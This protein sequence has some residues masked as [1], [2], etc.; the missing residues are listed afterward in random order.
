MLDRN[1]PLVEYKIEPLKIFPGEIQSALTEYDS[2]K[3]KSIFHPISEGIIALK[4]F[5]EE[6]KDYEEE[7]SIEQL[8]KLVEIINAIN[9]NSVATSN[10]KKALVNLIEKLKPI[11]A[12]KNKNIMAY[13]CE[14]PTHR[15]DALELFNLTSHIISPEKLIQFM[16]QTPHAINLLKHTFDNIN[17]LPKHDKIAIKIDLTQATAIRGIL[18]GEKLWSNPN[19][20][21]LLQ[22]FVY[23]LHAEAILYHGIGY[24][25]LV[26]RENIEL[27]SDNYN[28]ANNIA[29]ALINIRKAELTDAEILELEKRIDHN[30]KHKRPHAVRFANTLAK[31][32]PG[33]ILEFWD[34]FIKYDEAS[35]N[36]VKVLNDFTEMKLLDKSTLLERTL[37]NIKNAPLL[38]DALRYFKQNALLED[39]S[40]VLL[41]KTTNLTNSAFNALRNLMQTSTKPKKEDISSIL[42]G[43]FQLSPTFFQT[44]RSRS[45]SHSESKRSESKRSRQSELGPVKYESLRDLK[46]NL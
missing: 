41:E 21:N 11:L 25:K 31:A 26:T 37:V 2:L 28:N 7:L 13:A 12:I 33:L 39:F 23:L 46:L 17:K 32:D 38:S 36:L 34:F 3:K 27:I 8:Y 4:K 10:T 22:L 15:K 44:P 35:E 43:E 1:E 29:N 9:K 18:F 5:E 14:F 16:R 30:F 6:L 42:N 20:S 40:S 24:N 45:S 19:A